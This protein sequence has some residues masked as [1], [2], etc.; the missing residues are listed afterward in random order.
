MRTV[1]KI[2]LY[3]RL[4]GKRE[5]LLFHTVLGM[6]LHLKHTT[7]HNLRLP[8]HLLQSIHLV[9]RERQDC[10]IESD[11]RNRVAN[12]VVARTDTR[13]THNVLVPKGLDGF[14]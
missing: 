5:D 8:L 2:G 13:K 3:Q 4:S 10:D 7:H 12:K 9:H 11:I 6:S 14:T 1:F